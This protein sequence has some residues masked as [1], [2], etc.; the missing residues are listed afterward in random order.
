MRDSSIACLSSSQS[1]SEPEPRLASHC[2]KNSQ[3]SSEEENRGSFSSRRAWAA[4]LSH[5]LK[6]RPSLRAC[7]TKRSRSS[8]GIISW[9]LAML[10]PAP[11]SQC[12][13]RL[14]INGVYVNGRERA[15]TFPL[16]KGCIDRGHRLHTFG[17]MDHTY[18]HGIPAKEGAHALES[19]VVAARCRMRTYSTSARSSMGFADMCRLSAR[20]HKCPES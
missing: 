4:A 15:K 16:P 18:R 13:Y 5:A 17:D 12:V 3:T 1:G 19:M 20:Y 7:R 14:H 6:V 11:N 2:R 9:T 10:H 8:S